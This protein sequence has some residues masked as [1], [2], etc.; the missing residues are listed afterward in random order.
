MALWAAVYDAE[1]RQLSEASLD[2][3]VCDCC[4][5]SVAETSD[6]AIVAYRD[7]SAAEVRDIAVTRFAD[8]RWSPPMPVHADGWTINGCPVNGPAVDARDRHV[9]VA[10]FTASAG[11]GQAFVAFSDDAGR[12]FGAPVRVDDA[13]CTGHV[14]VELLSDGSAAATW[15][16]RSDERAEVKMRRVQSNGSRSPSVRVA[17][18]S[19]AEY[20]RLAHAAASCWLP[21][22]RRK[23]ATRTFAWRES[24]CPL[25][26]G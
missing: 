7:R 6:G 8:G 23:T 12:T 18:V 3:R 9:A 15:T 17:Q 20:P 14:D 11:D 19:S 10:W 24:R 4:Q 22:P 13:A 21:G 1:G 16:E 26:N 5:T 2:P 25:G